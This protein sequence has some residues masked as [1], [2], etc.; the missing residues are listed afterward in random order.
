MVMIMVLGALET[1][2]VLHRKKERKK[3]GRP[4]LEGVDY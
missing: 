1:L 4:T 2:G 3:G